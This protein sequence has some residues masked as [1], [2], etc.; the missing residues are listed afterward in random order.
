MSRNKSI[1]EILK[2]TP[3]VMVESDSLSGDRVMITMPVAMIERDPEFLKL[4]AG[5]P[6]GRLLI[7]SVKTQGN[8]YPPVIYIEIVDGELRFY[9]VDG[10]QRLAAAL[11]NNQQDITVIWISRWTT[12]AQAM[13]EAVDLQYARKDMTEADVAVLL[14]SATLT[15]V[16]IAK[17][18]GYSENK[19]SR[20]AKVVMT[21]DA[22]LWKF[23][24]T[25]II[26]LSQAVK[27]IDACHEQPLKER[28]LRMTMDSLHAIAEEKADKAKAKIDRD[29][30]KKWPKELIQQS[31]ITSHFRPEMWREI[32]DALSN[33]D[34]IDI[35][36]GMP[37]L[38]LSSGDRP[39]GGSSE[40]SGVWIADDP[41]QWDQEFAVYGIFE[42]KRSE[43][44]PADVQEVLNNFDFIKSCLQ[45]I[46][47][48][49]EIPTLRP[50]SP[51]K[52]KARPSLMDASTI[53]FGGDDDE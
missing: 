16:E 21:E 17:R 25:K 15:Q 34:A 23:V 18:T 28:A 27:L 42:R 2:S 31:K 52:T 9:V 46:V 50:T 24:R 6:D 11:A 1:I 8:V 33:E 30:K 39:S 43:V 47:D 20:L 38:R 3:K 29:P 51:R 49:R 48:G 41:A 5:T 53:D 12:K 10:H 35:S 22:W 32:E 36:D 40:M 4:R 14:T 13:A 7:E 44:D 26:P 19:I 45:A 37:T